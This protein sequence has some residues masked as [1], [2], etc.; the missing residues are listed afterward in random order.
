[1]K[2]LNAVFEGGGV[3][4]IGLVGALKRVEEKGVR[5]EAVAGTSAGAIVAALYAAGYESGDIKDILEAT[6]FAGLLDPAPFWW[7]LRRPYGVHKGQKI[8]EWIYRLLQKKGVKQ[9]KDLEGKK[10]LV[11]IASDLTHQEILRFDK[12]SNPKMF[13]AEAVRMSISIPLFFRA[14]Q[15]GEALVVDGGILSNYPLWVFDSSPRR[16]IGFKL[17]SAAEEAVPIAPASFVGFLSAMLGTMMAAHDKEDARDQRRASTIHIPTR[18]IRATQ[19]HLSEDEKTM[20]YNSGYVAATEFLESL[21]REFLGSPSASAMQAQ[22]LEAALAPIDEL[23]KRLPHYDPH[24]VIGAGKAEPSPADRQAFEEA[25]AKLTWTDQ[26][27]IVADARGMS[28]YF[29][30]IATYW[31]TVGDYDRAISR[32]D[33]AL[34]LAPDSASAYAELGL[35]FAFVASESAPGP[36]KATLLGRAAGAIRQQQE[37]SGKLSARVLHIAAW[38]DDERGEYKAAVEKYQAA[39]DAEG[40]SQ[41]SASW[42]LITYNLAC[43]LLKA[44]RPDDAIEELAQVIDRDENWVWAGKDPDFATLHDNPRFQALLE[45]ARKRRGLV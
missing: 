13:V 1:V 35:A 37:V 26:L 42:A 3:R 14:C 30:K 25:D 39:R 29:E 43:A 32:L 24:F 38:I 21:G 23:F 8:Y 4:G 15:L 9:F 40:G 19:F 18:S 5:F 27:K 28:K 17:V 20:L 6:D 2:E 45:G 11:I 16:T 12:Q 36:A 22:V 41:E 34:T 33:R 44:K 31:R 10:D 7:L